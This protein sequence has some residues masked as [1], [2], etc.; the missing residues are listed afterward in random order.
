VW[1]HGRADAGGNWRDDG[2]GDEEEIVFRIWKTPP[3][4]GGGVVIYRE[5]EGPAA[6]AVE[7]K[8]A[9]IPVQVM[10]VTDE[11]MAVTGEVPA[12]VTDFN[13]VMANVSA[14]IEGCLSLGSNSA[15]E[16]AKGQHYGKFGVHTSGFICCERNIELVYR[17]VGGRNCL[18]LNSYKRVK[19]F[20]GCVNEW[21]PTSHYG[22]IN[23]N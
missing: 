10:A 11:V 17:K 4:L 21:R 16:E 20:V 18:R 23:K 19:A 1:D 5:L 8:I 12:V 3:P 22:Y 6:E 9:A 2:E 15:E 7:A 13:A 14:V